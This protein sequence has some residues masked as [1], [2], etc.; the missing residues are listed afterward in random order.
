[1]DFELQQEKLAAHFNLSPSGR[2]G[3]SLGP[4]LGFPLTDAEAFI[5]D[6]LDS[7]LLLE[8]LGSPAAGA[9]DPTPLK[10]PLDHL[11]VDSLTLLPP[12]DGEPYQ[13]SLEFGVAGRCHGF[14]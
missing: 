3:L 5:R 11:I 6:V 10:L 12:S 9:P 14:D 1:M 13:L 2:P 8:I 4:D 7:S